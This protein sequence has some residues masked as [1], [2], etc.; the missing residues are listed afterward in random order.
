V[1]PLRS[2][3]ALRW[4]G[5]TALSNLAKGIAHSPTQL[6]VCAAVRDGVLLIAADAPAAQLTEIAALVAAR[7]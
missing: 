4:P 5:F 2:L 7:P 3:A 6:M 1:S